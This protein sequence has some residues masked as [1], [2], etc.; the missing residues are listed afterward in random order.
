MEELYLERGYFKTVKSSK[1]SV[2]KKK[3]EGK[4]KKR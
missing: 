1:K 4:G 3:E 2:N